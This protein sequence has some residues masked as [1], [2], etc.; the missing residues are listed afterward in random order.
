MAK[1]K[2][3]YIHDLSLALVCLGL[4]ALMLGVGLTV[5][6]IAIQICVVGV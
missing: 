4:G 6:Y 1:D 3:K 5:L 2:V